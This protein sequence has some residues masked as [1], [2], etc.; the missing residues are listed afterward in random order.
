MNVSGN[1]DVVQRVGGCEYGDVGDVRF[2]GDEP[3]FGTVASTNA[4]HAMFVEA[5]QLDQWVIDYNINSSPNEA[6]ADA[7]LAMETVYSGEVG[8]LSHGESNQG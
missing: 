2:V 4:D 7:A 8:M 6:H 5:D 3:T 1:A